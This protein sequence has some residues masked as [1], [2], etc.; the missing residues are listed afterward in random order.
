MLAGV[1]LFARMLYSINPEAVLLG[2]KRGGAVMLP[3]LTPPAIQ[4]VATQLDLGM[5]RKLLTHLNSKLIYY[6]G[7]RTVFANESKLSAGK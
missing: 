6:N 7:G 3:K 5:P 4:T 1:Y 2:A